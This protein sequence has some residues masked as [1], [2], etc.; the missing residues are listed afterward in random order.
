[1]KTFVVERDVSGI[2]AADLHMLAT[3]THRQVL[4]MREEGDL[5]HYLGSTF[6][7][8]EG[9]CLCLFKAKNEAVLTALSLQAKLP[10]DRI[11]DAVQ[12]GAG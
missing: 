2:S 4:R 3:R 8:A 11:L 9:R 12:V 1:M 7:A 6:L 5:V 10:L